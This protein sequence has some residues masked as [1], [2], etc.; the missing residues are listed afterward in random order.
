MKIN[1]SVEKLYWLWLIRY[2]YFGISWLWWLSFVLYHIILAIMLYTLYP[3][4]LEY[5]TYDVIVL[6]KENVNPKRLEK[7]IED[8]YHPL[9]MEPIH[10]TSFKEA[11]STSHIIQ[12]PEKVTAFP[13][14][15][16]LTLS[17]HIH[18][19]PFSRISDKEVIETLSHEPWVGHVIGGPIDYP[20]NALY[21]FKSFIFLLCSVGFILGYLWARSVYTLL[22]NAIRTYVSAT[23]PLRIRKEVLSSYILRIKLFLTKLLIPSYI[24]LLYMLQWI[25]R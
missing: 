15:W 8:T 23:I 13:N 17:R 24:T 20:L 22:E 9:V 21:I 5:S 4:A 3:I 1:V 19:W 12:H 2:G 16:H 11:L 10:P 25:I 14:A 6:A 7:L 18:L